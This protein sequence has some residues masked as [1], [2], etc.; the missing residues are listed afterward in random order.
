MNKTIEPGPR[1]NP[2]PGVIVWRLHLKSS[3]SSTYQLLSTDE[4][5][6]RFW[7]EKS[8]ERDGVIAWKFVDGSEFKSKILLK[9]PPRRFALEY[10]GGSRV[11]FETRDDGQ[12]GTDLTVT[13][14]TKSREHF[15]E[16]VPGWVSVLMALKATSDFSVDLRSHDTRRTW[17]QGY[18]D[19]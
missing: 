9:D 5:R 8:L 4:G 6:M 12:G 13:D 7:A 17:D 3:P 18:C 2:S 10:F 1:F 11:T 19:N 16:A 14:E 15:N